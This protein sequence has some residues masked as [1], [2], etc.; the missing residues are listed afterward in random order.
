MFWLFFVAVLLMIVGPAV[1]ALVRRLIS[2]TKD[3]EETD[4]TAV[5]TVEEPPSPEVIYAAIHPGMAKS[6][7]E[8]DDQA[9]KI[10]T[11]SRRTW[12]PKK[13]GAYTRLASLPRLK[14]AV[15]WSEILKPPRGLE[16]FE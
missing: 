10:E 2:S 6:G 11:E 4:S 1:L 15:M 12:N 7:A 14:R 16:P 8:D 9:V 3:E 13:P 5:Q